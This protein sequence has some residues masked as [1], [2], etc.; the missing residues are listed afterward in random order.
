MYQT[1]QKCWQA[2]CP[3]CSPKQYSTVCY[4]VC[5]CPTQGNEEADIY[6]RNIP[7]IVIFLYSQTYIAGNQLF[8]LEFANKPAPATAI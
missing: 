6:C 5:I 2:L 8:L 3:P 7:S 1:L 4:G